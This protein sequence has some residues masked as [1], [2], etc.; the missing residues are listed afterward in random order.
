MTPLIDEQRDASRGVRSA[1]RWATRR[2]D[3]VVLRRDTKSEDLTLTPLSALLNPESPLLALK[4][5]LLPMRG[6]AYSPD[7][8]SQPSLALSRARLTAFSDVFA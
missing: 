4:G 3:P 5:A 2:P 6:T 7:I 1:T 8:D